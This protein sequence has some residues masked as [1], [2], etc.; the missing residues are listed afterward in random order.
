MYKDVARAIDGIDIYPMIGVVI[1]FSVFV[2]MIVNVYSAKKSNV[3]HW[4]ALPLEDATEDYSNSFTPNT[5][6][7][8]ETE[9]I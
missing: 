7:K 3:A 6:N 4:E 8:N 1:F 9:T 2:I 5:T